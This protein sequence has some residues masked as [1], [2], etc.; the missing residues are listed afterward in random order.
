MFTDVVSL[1]AA[2]GGVAAMIWLIVVA[3]QGDPERRAEEAARAY[4]DEHGRWPDE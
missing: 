1:V 2:A 3:F 4:F